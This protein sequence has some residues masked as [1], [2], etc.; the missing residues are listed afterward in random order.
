MAR[1]MKV[2]KHIPNTMTLFNIMVGLAAILFSISHEYEKAAGL[3]L[4]SVIVDSFDGYV[5]RM[6]KSTSKFGGYMDTVSDF[7]AFA[8]A[9][10]ILMMN[11]FGVHPLA[12]AFFVFASVFRLWYFMKTKNVTHFFGVPTTVAGGLLAT[13]AILRPQMGGDGQMSALM[14]I[15]MVILSALML[16]RWK[17]YRIE[18]RKRR[19]LTLVA[20]GLMSL[21]AISYYL[22]M[23]AAFC[24]F[25]CY[26]FFGWLPFFRRKDVDSLIP[27]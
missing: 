5:A 6:L 26:I 4:V 7:L 24:L 3:I 1:M 22:F 13:I 8:L 16:V 9:A 19:T 23:F 10:A 20:A 18:I 14:S 25:V 11:E 21:L 17:Y 12:A 2:A 27:E 15:V